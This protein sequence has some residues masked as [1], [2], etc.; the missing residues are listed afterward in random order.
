MLDG[1]PDLI[2]IDHDESTARHVGRTADG[3]QFFLTNPFVPTN[4]PGAD[5]GGEF[6][7]L[8]LFDPAGKL[9]E[10]R[11]DAFGPSAT[12]DEAEWRRVYEERLRELGDVALGRIEVAPFAIERFGVEFGLVPREPEEDEDDVWA[13]EAQP[14]NYMAFFEPWDSGDYDT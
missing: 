7:A 8:Y 9:L 10:A 3:R 5:G 4:E 13:V 2:A 1:P 14:G 11:I 12:V 6:V